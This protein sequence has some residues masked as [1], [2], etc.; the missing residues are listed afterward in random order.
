[1]ANIYLTSNSYIFISTYDIVH[2]YTYQTTYSTH[3]N[4]GELMGNG[5]QKLHDTAS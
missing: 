1:M 2:D 3:R 4:M 5:F